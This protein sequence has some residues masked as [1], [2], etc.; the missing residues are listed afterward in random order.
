M[1]YI[2]GIHALNIPCS[3][4][5]SGDWHTDALKWEK[6]MYL[7]SDNSIWCDYGIECNKYVPMLKRYENVANHIRAVLDLIE[8]GNFAVANGMRKDFICTNIYDNEIFNHIPLLYQESNWIQ[9]NKFM[10]KE[11]GRKWIIYAK[12]TSYEKST[13]N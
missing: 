13:I 7:Q 3:L 1:V 9:I 6:I 11:Y 4:Q 2:S 8:Q 12:E 5:T 10:A